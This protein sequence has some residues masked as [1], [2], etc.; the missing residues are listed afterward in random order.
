MLD[1]PGSHLFLSPGRGGVEMY[2]L[3][4]GSSEFCDLITKML[5]SVRNLIVW[6]FF[7]VRN[8]HFEI[9]KKC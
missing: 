9:L 8:E 5:L 7:P 2:H 1:Y 3:K 4:E 6:V